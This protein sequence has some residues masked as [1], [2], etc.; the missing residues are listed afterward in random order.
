[1]DVSKMLIILLGKGHIA[2]SSN[3]IKN[4]KIAENKKLG[5]F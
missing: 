1:M 4:A 2:V 3:N 5:N